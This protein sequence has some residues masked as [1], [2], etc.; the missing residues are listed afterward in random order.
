MA[1][2]ASF[3]G[4]PNRFGLVMIEAAFTG[5]ADWSDAVTRYIA[6]NFRIFKAGVDAIPGLSVMDMESTYLAWVDFADT[7]MTADEFNRRV[8]DDARIAANRGPTFGTGGESYLRFNIATRRALI[9]EAVA[10]LTAAFGDL[11]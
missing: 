2:R 1:P 3:G 10:R 8:A 6:E 9:E 11:Q 7:G 5:G 4:S